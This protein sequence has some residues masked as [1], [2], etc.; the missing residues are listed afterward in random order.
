MGYAGRIYGVEVPHF[1]EET[2]HGITS[3]TGAG[4]PVNQT[5]GYQPGGWGP[6]EALSKL[7][8][9]F[10]DDLQLFKMRQKRWQIWIYCMR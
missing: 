10:Q 1:S 6:L 5:S 7:P 2:K 9:G 8:K 4:V 3:T